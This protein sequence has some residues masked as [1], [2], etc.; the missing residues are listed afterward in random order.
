MLL[1]RGANSNMANEDLMTPVDYG[2]D[3]RSRAVQ[4]L[5]RS[6]RSG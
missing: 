3:S 5:A 4:R 1:N 2:L 6:L